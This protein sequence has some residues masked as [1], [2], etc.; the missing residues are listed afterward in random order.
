P[1]LKMRIGEIG[2]QVAVQP[3]LRGQYT[4]AENVKVTDEARQA[5]IYGSGVHTLG[6]DPSITAIDFFHLIDDRD[7]VHYQ[8]GLL[9]VDG[10][11]RASYAAVR[12]AIQAPCAAQKPW[13]HAT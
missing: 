13:P 8:S 4:S 5:K 10:S 2:W 6:C 1:F 12:A 7:L 9:R 11:A 3:S